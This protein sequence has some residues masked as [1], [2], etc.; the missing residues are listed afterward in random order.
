LSE[1]EFSLTEGGLEAVGRL[2]DVRRV[3]FKELLEW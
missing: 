3:G 1:D 2:L